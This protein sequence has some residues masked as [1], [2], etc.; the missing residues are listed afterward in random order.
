MRKMHV[1]N[2]PAVKPIAKHQCIKLLKA[3]N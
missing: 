1:E 3:D 2:D